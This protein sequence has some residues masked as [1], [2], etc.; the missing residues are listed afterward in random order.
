MQTELYTNKGIKAATKVSLN[1]SIFARRVN[2]A[3]LAQAIYIYLNNQRQSN[4]HT[5]DKSEVSGGGRKPWRQKGTGRARHGSTRSPIWR[6][7]GVTFG[8]TNARNYKGTLSKKMRKEA[9]RSAFSEKTKA[10]QVKI[11]AG[12]DFPETKLTQSLAATLK[13]AG[14]SGKTLILQKDKNEKLLNAASN[15]KQVKVEMVGAV[16]VYQLLNNKNLVI[17]QDALEQINQFWGGREAAEKPLKADKPEVKAT[18]PAAKKVE[19]KPVTK[20]VKAKPMKKAV[21]K[22]K[23]KTAKK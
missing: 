2:K 12:F 1:D 18:K 9:I 14:V 19:K 17:M 20:A 22:S 15:L 3:L 6:H 23:P 10:E 5:K 16:S 4:A 11:F 13:K 7:G 21:A 8:P